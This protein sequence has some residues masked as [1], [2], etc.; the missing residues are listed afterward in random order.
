MAS[1][2]N[3]KDP[4]KQFIDS[5]DKLKV[6]EASNTYNI[7]GM[8]AGYVIATFKSMV[9]TVGRYR[10]S[11]NKVFTFNICRE[12][13]PTISFQLI[14]KPSKDQPGNGFIGRKDPRDG[15]RIIQY[16]YNN[17][18]V[19]K[20]QDQYSNDTKKFAQD[21]KRVFKDN[22]QL[23]QWENEIIK[24]VYFLLLFEIGRRLVKDDP[25]CTPRKRGLDNLRISEAITMIVKLFENEE[26]QFEDVFLKDKSYHCFSAEEPKIRRD[27]ISL[28]LTQLEELNLED[29]EELFHVEE[30]KKSPE[31]IT[32]RDN[33]SA[34]E[35][36][37]GISREIEGL[38]LSK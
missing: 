8:S 27:A 4:S 18:L 15:G 14:A 21:I 28:L 6:P 1:A 26:C 35:P 34:E 2:E 12:D 38:S 17:D 37:A 31:D 5:L 7:T 33:E 25:K 19:Q 20:L 10:Y 30:D 24:D 16:S 3:P 11:K 23:L 13:Q 9:N 29:I 32:S 22:S 36:D